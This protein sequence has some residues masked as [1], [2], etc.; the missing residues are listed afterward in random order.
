MVLE[1]VVNDW[2]VIFLKRTDIVKP[3]FSNENN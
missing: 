3:N 1:V 2:A